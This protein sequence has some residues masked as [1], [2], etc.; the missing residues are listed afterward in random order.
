MLTRILKA[1]HDIL[2]VAFF[3]TFVKRKYLCCHGEFNLSPYQHKYAE[4]ILFK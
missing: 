2:A 4:D 3:Q 1:L